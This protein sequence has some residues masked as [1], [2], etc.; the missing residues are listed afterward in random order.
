VRILLVHN[1][2][3]SA[4]PSGENRVVADEIEMLRGAD[5]EVH[6]YLRSSDEIPDFN[7]F[8][9]LSMPVRP[10]YSFEDTRRFRSRLREIKPDVVHLHNPFPLIS[11]WVVRISKHAGVPVVQTVHNYR[12][13]C[14]AGVFYRDGHVCEDC[15]GKKIPWPGVKHSCYRDS[16]AQSTVMAA[17]LVAHRSTWQMVDEFLPVSDCVAQHLVRAGIAR[18]RIAVKPN[19]LPD[20]GP[21]API[22]NGFL[23]AAR[24]SPEKGVNL[25][26]DAWSR[27]G[28]DDATPL[29]IAGD[30]EDRARVEAAA[31]RMPGVRYVGQQEHAEILRLMRDAAVV[32]VPSTWYEGFPM[33]VTEAFAAGRPVLATRI[34]SLASIVDATVGWHAEPDVASLA[35]A[36]GR[37][38]DRRI[39]GE[40][41]ATAR[42]RFE[43]DLSTE[44]VTKRLLESYA[45]VSTR[46]AGQ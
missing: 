35:T 3:R 29:V 8:G 30:G 14:S 43:R 44:A 31:A 39:A 33:L 37:A 45:R 7:L 20:P 6:T 16:R 4:F 40:L 26:L 10:I 12:H 9:K 22:G 24:L 13:V 23:F 28:L 2:Y 11:P 5:V 18:D 15:T 46:S 32:V 27:A 34:G 21:P 38:T 19:A 1:Q 17:A 36:L 42:A 25:L 41:G